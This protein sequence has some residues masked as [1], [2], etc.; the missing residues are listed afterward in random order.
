M[1]TITVKD[2]EKS[3]NKAKEVENNIPKSRCRIR[4][5]QYHKTILKEVES[6]K[7][8][9]ETTKPIGMVVRCSY[10]QGTAR[11]PQN[12]TVTEYVPLH[13]TEK[14]TEKMFAGYRKL[15]ILAFVK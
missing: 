14:E 8:R 3:I 4:Q 7:T 12:I 10:N 2:F 15:N 1:K 6:M 5:E 13:G 9:K 11:Y